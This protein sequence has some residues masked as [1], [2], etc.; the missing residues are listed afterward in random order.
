M[1]EDGADDDGESLI[2]VDDSRA[3]FVLASAELNF[4]LC[5]SNGNHI[6]NSKY[7]M[8]LVDKLATVLF[9]LFGTNNDRFECP[10]N[11]V[12]PGDEQQQEVVVASVATLMVLSDEKLTLT[13]FIIDDD[14]H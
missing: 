11:T 9:I 5:G 2:L 14:G 13:F 3:S 6:S 12:L 10:A 4:V 7:G 8:K 1:G